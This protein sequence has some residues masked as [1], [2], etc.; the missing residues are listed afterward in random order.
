MSALLEGT[1]VAH[2]GRES[3]YLPRLAR[4]ASV[5]QMTGT[6]KVFELEQ[7][8]GLGH[9][10]GQFVEVS[11][12][13]VGEAPISICSSPT[14]GPGFRIC[15]RRVG[16]LTTYL[17]GLRQGSWVGLRG[18]FGHGFPM[19]EA[20]GMDLLFVAGGIG[21]APM[22]S[23]IRYALDRRDRYGEITVIYTARSA[24]SAG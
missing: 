13:G 16:A 10:P 2:H 8:G 4:I 17:H 19:E 20:E 9:R 3:I 15:V 21:M 22:R 5:E 24:P 12:P 6:E 7:E 1:A 23:A 11:A 18:P 14:E